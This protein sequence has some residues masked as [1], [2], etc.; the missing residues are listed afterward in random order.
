[1]FGELE[2]LRAPQ[3]GALRTAFGLEGGS[4]PDRFMVGLA[5]LGLFAEVAQVRPVVLLIDDAQW[6][7]VASAQVIGFA[8]R[9][10]G[11]ESVGLIFAARGSGTEIGVPEL[12]RLPEMHVTGL[13]DDDARALLALTHPGPVDDRVLDRIVAECQGN[14]LALLELPRGFTP[15]ELAGG[16]GLLGTSAL[17]RRIEESFRRQIATL[18]PTMRQVLL[19]AAAEPVGD[20]VLVWRAVDRLG[21]G[22]DIDL[23]SEER[24]RGSWSSV[25]GDVPP[26]VAAICDLPRGNSRGSAAGAPGAGAGDRPDC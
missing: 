24:R 23:A 4:P 3:R 6:L 13:P 25:P 19:V 16:F 20:P 12:A 18:S 14:P 7:D 15:A 5:V 2:L 21:L 22:A 10:L 1:M 26:S 9:R 8:A 17:P 11:T